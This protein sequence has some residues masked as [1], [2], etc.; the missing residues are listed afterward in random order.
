MGW[1]ALAGDLN[2]ASCLAEPLQSRAVGSLGPF[3]CS[4]SF[5]G[6]PAKVRSTYCAVG[7]SVCG[8]LWDEQQ[9]VSEAKVERE[10]L[11]LHKC[12][13]CGILFA[14]LC[15]KYIWKRSRGVL[16]ILDDQL[17]ARCQLAF[18]AQFFNAD[19]GSRQYV[20]S[21]HLLNPAGE[22]S[23]RGWDTRQK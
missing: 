7:R 22:W 2:A 23:S 15:I 12:W 17:I 11:S 18:S 16:C 20:R 5:A 4:I 10:I 1:L 6:V 3:C 9:V 21:R 19:F 8:H 14:C 13:E